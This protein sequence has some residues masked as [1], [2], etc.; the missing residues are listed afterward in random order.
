MPAVLQDAGDAGHI[1]IVHKVQQVLPLVQ[2][3][4]LRTELPFQR[5]HDLKEIVRIEA[6]IQPFITFII[7][8]AVQHL[9]VDPAVVIPVQQF[10]DQKEI[11]LELPAER[12]QQ[13]QEGRR[14]TVGDIQA[15]SVDVILLDPFPDAVKQIGNDG[16]VLQVQLHQIVMSF[17]AF[18]PETVVLVGIP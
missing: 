16:R 3:P 6:G 13:L 1:V 14:Q 7:R 2:R 15:Q 8:G 5:M 4:L 11:R 9:F 10:S 18:I 17:P 12:M